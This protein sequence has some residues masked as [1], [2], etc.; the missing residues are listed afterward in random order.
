MDVTVQV[1][2]PVGIGAAG[3]ACQLGSVARTLL[4]HL[5]APA[6][7]PVSVDVLVDAVYGEHAV[8][9]DRAALR[10]AVYRLRRV[11]GR[12]AISFT[13]DAYALQPRA[14]EV[15]AARFDD[16]LARACTLRSPA[17]IA[18][19]LGAALALWRGRRFAQHVPAHP[20]LRVWAARLD[21]LRCG[22]TEDLAA[23]HLQL[24]QPV[25][26]RRSLQWL[27]AEHPGRGRARE[28]L[29]SA[30]DRAEPAGETV[31]G[32][33]RTRQPRGDGIRVVRTETTITIELDGLDT[34]E[35]M[36]ITLVPG[37]E[38]SA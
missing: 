18:E 24:Q 1:L 8:D 34:S 28:L 33:R 19:T 20:R 4:A 23:A 27:L 21:E 15:D 38:R 25:H 10:K 31:A 5:A 2:G 17:E 12:D 22:A 35:P 32:R 7:E 11:L 16:L 30:T 29:A 14:C 26:A 37:R 9:G 13:G 6:G 3:A 36:K